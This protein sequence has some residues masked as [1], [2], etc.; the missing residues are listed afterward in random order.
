MRRSWD[1]NVDGHFAAAPVIIS[2]CTK[3]GRRESIG[4]L[5]V[6]LGPQASGEGRSTWLRRF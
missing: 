1:V 3:E 6:E 5:R 2:R 4:N